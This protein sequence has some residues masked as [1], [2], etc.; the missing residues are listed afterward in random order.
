LALASEAGFKEATIVSSGD[1][2]KR[3]FTGRTDNLHPAS[4]EDFLVATT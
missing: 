4:G 3:Y 1:I 2:T